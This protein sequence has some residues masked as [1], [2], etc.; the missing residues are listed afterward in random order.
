[1]RTAWK[2]YE[3]VARYLLDQNAHELGLKRVEGKQEIPG[4]GSGTC[5]EIDA[6]GIR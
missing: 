5:Y 4:R 1:V 6:K 2:S 3:E